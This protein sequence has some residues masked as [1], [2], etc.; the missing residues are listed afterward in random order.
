MNPKNQ[1]TPSLSSSMNT[2]VTLPHESLPKNVLT[3]TPTKIFTQFFIPSSQSETLS[4]PSNPT[5]DDPQVMLGISDPPVTIGTS[6]A[7]TDLQDLADSSFVAL[8]EP[9]MDDDFN[10]TDPG[11]LPKQICDHF[12]SWTQKLN[13]KGIK[14]KA[15]D[16][17]TQYE[18][19][20][21]TFQKNYDVFN[22]KLD[23][24]DG[25]ISIA[26]YTPWSKNSIPH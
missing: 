17:Q 6:L 22:C 2:Q 12:G 7:T 24:I 4:S 16:L 5:Q 19:L 15:N 3:S 23:T 11:S 1:E 21:Q 10:A 20:Q 9:F 18:L 8:D 14:H 26:L 25:H 13:L